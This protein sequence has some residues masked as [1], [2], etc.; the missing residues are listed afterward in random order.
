[1]AAGGYIYAVQEVGTP[2]VKIGAT[3]QPMAMR[4]GELRAQYHVPLA[5]IAAVPVT[6]YTFIVERRVHE[7]LATS[8]IQGEWFYLY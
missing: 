4:L 1:M 3:R 8:R 5:L 7:Q 6:A 2:L